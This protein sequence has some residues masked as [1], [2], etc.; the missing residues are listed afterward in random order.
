VASAQPLAPPR[1]LIRRAQASTPSALDARVRLEASAQTTSRPQDLFDA[2]RSN[3]LQA[4]DY[5][6]TVDTETFSHSL[7]LNLSLPDEL[8]LKDIGNTR[9]R[10]D[11]INVTERLNFIPHQRL[12]FCRH[13]RCPVPLGARLLIDH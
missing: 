6:Q 12:Q 2:N 10:V 5:L 9:R 3:C 1:S 4:S 13:I 11:S 8:L 7:Y